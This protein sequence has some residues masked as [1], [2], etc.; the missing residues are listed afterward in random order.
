MA[1]RKAA[2]PA[3]KKTITQSSLVNTSSVAKSNQAR[4]IIG[5]IVVAVLLYFAKGLFIAAL[6]DGKPISRLTII[7]RLEKQGGKTTLDSLVTETLILNDAAKKNITVSQKEID[8]QTKTIQTNIEKQGST[9]D[10]ALAQQGMTKSDLNQQIKLELT[11]NKLVGKA[12]PVTD[13]EIS[14]YIA[15]NKSQLPTGE[16]DNTLKGQVTQ[17]LTQQKQQQA[18]QAYVQSLKTKAKVTYF[19]N[20]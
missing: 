19:V 6:V 8:D 14:D 9:L 10:Q 18:I 1:Q 11:L 20:Y 12:A 7:H 5:I 4:I 13:K 16:D 17:Q 2:Q 3:T 15:Q